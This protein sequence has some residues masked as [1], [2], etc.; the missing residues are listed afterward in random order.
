[1]S[2]PAKTIALCSVE[3][4][5]CLWLDG[6]CQVPDELRVSEHEPGA[7]TLRKIEVWLLLAETFLDLLG[8]QLGARHPTGPQ[9]Q[10]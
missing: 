8:F 4:E 3:R 1:M 10:P 7:N 5:R 2:H 9:L 6:A